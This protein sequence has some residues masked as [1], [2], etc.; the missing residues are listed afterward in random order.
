VRDVH[1]GSDTEGTTIETN[2]T[3]PVAADDATGGDGSG[4]QP[5][6]P[7]WMS[8]QDEPTD[9]DRRRIATKIARIARRLRELDAEHSGA[10]GGPTGDPVWLEMMPGLLLDE[11]LWLDQG[12]TSHEK[13]DDLTVVTIDFRWIDVDTGGWIGPRTF[14]GY[15]ADGTDGGLEKALAATVRTYLR[16]TFLIGMGRDGVTAGVLPRM[17][18]PAASR[19]PTN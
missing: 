6:L 12:V 1:Q 9:A 17:R 15:G 4:C 11:G 8:G 13:R 5:T 14:I 10:I 3:M 7:A 16:H 18:R 2:D 19:R